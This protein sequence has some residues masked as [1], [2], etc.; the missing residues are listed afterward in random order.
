MKSKEMALTAIF[1][2]AYTALT[3]VLQPI[4]FLSVQVRVS[5]ALIMLLPLFPNPVLIGVTIGVFLSN[6]ASP[7]G[8]I[9]LISSLVT[10]AAMIPLYL[11]RDGKKWIVMLGGFI[12]SVIISLWVSYMLQTMI[13][14]PFSVSFLSVLIGDTIAVVGIGSILLFSLQKKIKGAII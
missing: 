7:L 5:G 13:G 1:A 10:L 12:K 11:M 3:L 9:D 8:P 4:S 14:L 2:A 6:L